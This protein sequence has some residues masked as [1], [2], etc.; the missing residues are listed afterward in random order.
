MM[1]RTTGSV[2]T[3]LLSVTDSREFRGPPGRFA[4]LNS[5]NQYKLYFI[6]ITYA[7]LFRCLRR[8]SAFEVREP[9]SPLKSTTGRAC[10]DL[11]LPVPSPSP[12]QAVRQSSGLS[13][14][15]L[16]CFILYMR[17]LYCINILGETNVSSEASISKLGSERRPSLP[18]A[19][20]RPPLPLHDSRENQQPP[21]AQPPN[22]ETMC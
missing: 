17:I 22:S 19:L 11:L 6:Q 15:Y 2:S 20:Q 14:F 16:Y 9:T 13:F 3:H 10:A 21:P 4:L 5:Y 8:A 7:G 18:P 12:P 1:R